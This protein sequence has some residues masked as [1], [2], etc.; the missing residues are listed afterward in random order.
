MS[1]CF[2][3]NICSPI[4]NRAVKKDK[5]IMKAYSVMKKKERR[6]PRYSVLN[7]ETS[8]DSPSVKSKGVRLDSAK[9]E[10]THNKSRIGW[11][12]AKFDPSSDV[13]QREKDF[14]KSTEE[15]IIKIRQ[16]SYEIVCAADR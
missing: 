9:H 12:S 2:N 13:N 6:P 5:K 10:K 4:K 3:Q 8:S 14:V 7:P 1:I 15:K 11:V 16:T